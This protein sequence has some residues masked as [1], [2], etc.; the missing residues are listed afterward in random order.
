VRL[1]WN[2]TLDT[3]QVAG[4]AEQLRSNGYALNKRLCFGETELALVT[5]RRHAAPANTPS[6]HHIEI[7]LGPTD[8]PS[9]LGHGINLCLQY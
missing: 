7:N 6:P 5:K 1:H 8:D 9:N 2:V 3:E 4:N